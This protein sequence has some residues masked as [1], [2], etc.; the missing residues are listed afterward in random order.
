MRSAHM[1]RNTRETQIRLSLN[2][3]GTGQSSVQ[4]GCGF[5]DHML[6]LFAAHGRFD[7]EVICEGD[8]QVDAHHTAEDVA[9]VLGKAFSTAL[10]NKMGITRYAHVV[11]PMDEAL[12]LAAV[13]VCGRNHLSFGLQIPS[14]RVG[15]FDTELVKE[16]FIAFVNNFPMALHLRQLAGENSHHIIE[17][18]F[19]AVARCLRQAL[20]IDATAPNSVPSTKGMLE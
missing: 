2:L 5:L 15:D 12:I 1:E 18:A 3:D 4:T 8:L 16:F 10:Q 7:L 14:P 6:T 19:K 13:D 20:A 11:L 17:G 9:I